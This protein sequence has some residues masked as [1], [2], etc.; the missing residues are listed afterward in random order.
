MRRKVGQHLRVQSQGLHAVA[1]M[2]ERD[3]EQNKKK[4][5]KKRK[6]HDIYCESTNEIKSSSIRPTLE[7]FR[8]RQRGNLPRKKMERVL[9]LPSAYISKHH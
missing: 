3:A 5:E 9:V 4:E 2:E 6:A 8:K 7:L 1:Y